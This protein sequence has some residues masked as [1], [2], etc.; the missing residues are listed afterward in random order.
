MQD[1]MQG[2]KQMA[3]FFQTQTKSNADI[4]NLDAVALGEGQKVECLPAIFLCK[5]QLTG[6]RESFGELLPRWCRTARTFVRC[7]WSAKHTVPLFR[8]LE[9]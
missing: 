3:I 7:T 6:S 9:L 4:A 8:L 1:E 5:P 2:R